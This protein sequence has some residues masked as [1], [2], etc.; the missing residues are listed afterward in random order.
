[1]DRLDD[2]V[3]LQRGESSRGQSTPCVEINYPACHFAAAVHC[4]YREN[5]AK[6]MTDQPTARW[7]TYFGLLMVA[8]ATLMFEILL[9]RIFSVTMWYHF[10][11]MAISVAMFGMTVGAIIVH[12]LPRYFT[13]EHVKHHLALGSLL[14]SLSI[15][16]A[17]LTHLSIPFVAEMS[18][19]GLYSMALTYVT[20]SLPF[21][22]SGVCVSL[23]ITRFQPQ[24]SRLYA[25]DLVGAALACPLLVY[26]LGFT[27]GP[28]AVVFVAFLA[29]LGSLFFC[30]DAADKKL[31][32]FVV[33]SCLI[34]GSFAAFNTIRS[35]EQTSLLR[36]LWVR[37]Q[38]ESAPLFEKWNSFSRVRVWGNPD[39]ARTPFGWGMSSA[40]PSDLRVKTLDMDID[41][42]AYT[43]I[44]AFSGNLSELDH[45]KYDVTNLA[46]YIRPQSKVLVIGVGGG[47]DI[48][49][50]L[51]FNQKSVLGVEINQSILNLINQRLGDYTGHLD[52]N[53]KVTI[54]N[55]E[56]RSYIARQSEK[57][58]IIE[59]SLVDTYAATAAGAFVLTENSLYTVEAWMSFLEH[60][61]PNGVLTF[62]RWY[63]DNPTEVYRLACLATTSLIQFGVKNP[64][65]HIIIVKQTGRIANLLVSIKPYTDAD[66][67]TLDTVSRKLGFDQVLT[68]RF[69]ADSTFSRIA[70]GR[71]LSSFIDSYPANISAPSDDSPFFFLT[72]RLRDVLNIDLFRQ[73]KANRDINT[74]PILILGALLIIV[75]G[76]SLLCIVAPLVLSRKY[77]SA[78]SLPPILF[79]AFIGFGFMLVEISQMQRLIIFLGHPIYG[80]SVVLFSLLLSSGLG[81]YSTQRT[82]IAQ[83]GHSGTLRLVFLLLTLTV[84]GIL[85]PHALHTFQA[86]TTPLRI[87]VAIGILFPL[88]FTMGMAFPL[89]MKAASTTTASQTAWLWGINGATSV[90][91]SVVA[92]VI[93]MSSSI[94]TAFWTGV[95]CYLIASAAFVWT[96]SRIDLLSGGGDVASLKS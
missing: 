35:N 81:S 26:S 29:G 8:L 17:F 62:S 94:S 67:D 5:G 32:R 72:L 24:M 1:L 48:L 55:D 39:S 36:L 49:S 46:H 82:V 4:S 85:T 18:I 50:A 61:T 78:G 44:T 65:S 58:D 31:L 80:L 42:Y 9:T 38:R 13:Q 69:S 86:S 41:A 12:L 92:V 79:F 66:L 6:S 51:A 91:A 54:V 53:P 30:L 64:R 74:V 93:A 71:D 47:R 84:F 59:S 63:W 83:L 27:D 11:F 57:F 28:T 10:A 68:P 14:F 40:L 88:G 37:G 77:P 21:V 34:L 89:G 45:L 52:Q 70:S 73:E 95:A 56:A 60:L 15:V 25:A 16:I 19:V 76:L 33:A 90:C 96:T 43:P 3:Y 2:V 23:A 7:Q 22:F 87:A 75:V 20:I